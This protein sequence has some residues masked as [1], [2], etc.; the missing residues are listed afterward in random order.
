MY[1]S[2][3]KWCRPCKAE[4]SYLTMTG[5]FFPDGLEDVIMK[6]DSNPSNPTFKHRG[7]V[8]LDY[9]THKE[10]SSAMKKLKKGVKVFG[11]E[12][13][14]D[15]AEPLAEVSDEVMAKVRRSFLM[16]MYCSV[17]LRNARVYPSSQSC[18][19]VNDFT[20]RVSCCRKPGKGMATCTVN[21]VCVTFEMYSSVSSLIPFI[22]VVT[23]WRDNCMLAML[24]GL[25]FSLTSGLFVT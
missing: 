2:V 9:K 18:S 13:F 5:A 4:P 1:H 17:C 11:Q 7:F 12:L 14:V 19:F 25:Y 24:Q 20:Q 16:C 8:F 23:C 21:C 15:W 22:Y 3:N 6:L 10:A